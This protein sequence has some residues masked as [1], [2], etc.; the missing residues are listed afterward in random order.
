MSQSRSD[1]AAADQAS[2]RLAQSEFER[3]VVVVAGAGTGKTALL[4]SRVVVWCVGP[5]W[6]RHAG[7]EGDRGSVARRVIERV[8]AI[9]FTEA[10]AAEMARKIGTALI[11]LAGG[12]SPIGWDPEPGLLPDDQDELRARARALSEES[13]RLVV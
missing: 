8:V 12:A 3:S 11:D 5:G 1:R 10:A 2:R 13:H 7:D 9:T 6:D 4:V